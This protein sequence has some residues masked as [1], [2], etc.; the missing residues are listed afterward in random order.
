ML[1]KSLLKPGK[2]TAWSFYAICESDEACSLVTWLNSLPKNLSASK[3]RLLA[4]IDKAATDAHGP[5]L[6]PVE[7]SHNVNDKHSIYEF[8]AG[9]LRLLWFY[10]PS[11]KKVIVCPTGF[12]K[13]S[14]KTPRKYI[15]EA[16]RA[17]KAYIKA[18]N[19]NNIV[20]VED[21]K[22]DKT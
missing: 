12:R 20:I 16:I 11:E 15:D 1:L 14:Q 17:K 22:N 5:Q 7:I 13:K 10:S 3:N 21:K 2:T 18:A 6:L 4:I 9:K 8:I 19:D